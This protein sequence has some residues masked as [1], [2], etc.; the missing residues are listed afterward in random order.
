MALHNLLLMTLV[1]LGTPGLLVRGVQAWKEMVA[2]VLAAALVRALL[3]AGRPRRRWLAPTDWLALGLAVILVLYAL[4]GLT[5][6]RHDVRPAQVAVGLRTLLLLPLMYLSGRVFQREAGAGDRWTAALAIGSFTVVGV[7]GLVELLFVPTRYWVDAGA[8]GY[9]AWS[10]YHYQ[11]PR[12][13]A[14]NFFQ[15]LPGDVLLRRM[16][17]TELSPLGIAYS[18]LLVVPFAVVLRSRVAGGRVRQLLATS[19]L[20]AMVAVGLTVTRL[21]VGLLVAE[22]AALL[23]LLRDRSAALFLVGASAVA[24]FVL[25]VYPQVGPATT[26]NLDPVGPALASSQ[27]API[28]LPPAII[29]TQ[30]SASPGPSTARVAPSGPGAAEP[31]SGLFDENDP[32]LRG[33]L[34]QLEKYVPYLLR[35]PLGHG[36][37]SSVHRFNNAPTPG[38]SAVLAF[39][40]ETGLVGGLLYLALYLGSIVAGFRA[41]WI[42]RGPAVG[43][44]AA[45]A[46]I[47]GLALAPVTLTSEVWGDLAVTFMFWW[48]AGS[49]VSASRSRAPSPPEAAGAPGPAGGR[50]TAAALS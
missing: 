47:G 19:V 45:V 12:G 10:G 22:A 3:A 40:G 6:F 11:G 35:D 31:G 4:L 43:A 7:F 33:H 26:R 29:G 28:P 46:G 16:V 5:V 48:A 24:A 30:T 32:S 1:R 27:Q 34:L 15:T 42:T 8:P 39:F 38:E 23:V 50:H 25:L 18:G 44:L 20:V 2:A 17:S 49:A 41:L 9:F 13:L 37:G 14:E 36:V 21:A